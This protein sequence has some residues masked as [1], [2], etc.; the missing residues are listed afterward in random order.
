MPGPRPR[1][2][3][4]CRDSARTAPRTRCPQRRHHCRD[5]APPD[6]LAEDAG[7]EHQQPD[8]AQ[9]ERR[10]HDRQRRQRQG[11]DLQRPARAP[12]ARW[13]RASGRCA[14]GARAARSA[15]MTRRDG[16]G[17]ERL[18]H[19]A[20]LE[21]RGR[22]GCEPR[23]ARRGGRDHCDDPRMRPA[24]L[25]FGAAAAA[26]S[27]PP[28][29]RTHRASLPRSVSPGGSRTPTGSRLTF[30]DGPHPG[31]HARGARGARCAPGRPRRSS[32]S[33][34]RSSAS[35]RW[36]AR[37]SPPATRGAARLAPP[38]QLLLTPR[39]LADD[40]AAG[41]RHG[42]GR[43]GRLA[44]A[45]PAALRDLQRGR[46]RARA[47]ARLAPLLWSR[48]GR[49]WAAGATPRSVARPRRARCDLATCAA[50]RRRQLQRRG[51]WRPPP[52]RCR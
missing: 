33:A 21:A 12:R 35:P 43:D 51:L 11:G 50:P 20:G 22:G 39:A 27:A 19:V 4:S 7:A 37:S 5:L 36:R 52:A 30:D 47:P 10:L 41:E 8:Q 25:A 13:P 29:R 1:R 45:L 34:S 16:A 32:S 44:A 17:L 31:G 2:R 3:C 9:Y 49:D 6:P 48:W 14:A 28:P 46:A 42:A 38:L 40:L 24:I 15:R 23:P 18:E 26:W